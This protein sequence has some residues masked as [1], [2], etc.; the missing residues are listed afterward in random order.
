MATSDRAY[1]KTNDT[2]PA[3]V[4]N[5]KN[6]DKSAHDLAGA[7]SVKLHIRLSNG[8]HFERAMTIVNPPGNDGKV[9]YQWLATDWIGSESLITGQHTM[10]YEVISGADRVTFPNA[11]FDVLEIT[12]DIAQG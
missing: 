4:V 9:K 3:L 7:T 10:E 6:P 1:L 2:A 8:R 11:S 12:H 5:L